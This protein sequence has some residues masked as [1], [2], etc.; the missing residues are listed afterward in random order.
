MDMKTHLVLTIAM[1]AIVPLGLYIVA[2]PHSGPTTRWLGRLA[3]A[4]P[5]V[6]IPSAATFLVDKGML[7]AA[8]AVPWFLLTLAVAAIG[9]A[10]MLSRRTLRST[11]IGYDAALMFLVVGGAWLVIS[12]AGL[13][14]L[15]FNFAIVELTAVHFHYAGFALPIMAS[16]V[17]E[18]LKRTAL[19]PALVIIGVPLT[20]IG[21]TV[22]GTTE[23]FAATFMSLVGIAVAVSTLQLSSRTT[24]KPQPMLAVAGLS[25][26]AGMFFALG[27]AWSQEFGWTY[28]DLSGM[29]STHGMLNG[30][31]FGLVGLIAVRLLP[32]I[33]VAQPTEV[34]LHLGRPSKQRLAE[35]RETALT[36]DTTSPLGILNGPTPDDMLLKVWRTTVSHGDFDRVKAGILAWAGHRRA[37]ISRVPEQL[38]VEVGGTLALAIPVGPISVT[39]TARVVEVFDEPNKFGFSYSTLPHHPVDGEE[40]F[41]VHRRDDGTLEMVVTAMF[42]DSVL[43]PQVAP[44]LTRFLQN[45]AINSYL[46]GI[47]TFSAYD[48]QLAPV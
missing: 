24:G 15:G 41:I 4:A 48:E 17:S 28:L 35:L 16:V 7:A 25:L 23:W 46:D 19:L 30:F 22:D 36:H 10:R 20:A 42:R 33:D 12:R 29:V 3:K 32:P 2:L 34:S 38:P 9:A 26:L 18:R 31:G 21:I 13:E 14:P 5:I 47:A 45:R 37:G 27:W 1:F 40:S 39:A 43:A 6:A 11:G 44:P 8:L